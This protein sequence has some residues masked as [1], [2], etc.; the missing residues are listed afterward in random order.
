MGTI[1]FMTSQLPSG[2]DPL[3]LLLEESLPR[4]TATLSPSP[5]VPQAESQDANDTTPERSSLSTADGL[6]R[7]DTLLITPKTTEDAPAS[8]LGQNATSDTDSAVIDITPQSSHLGAQFDEPLPASVSGPATLIPKEKFPALQSSDL[9]FP[10]LRN[11]E[12]L[13]GARSKHVAASEPD[14]GGLEALKERR[15]I[16]FGG[17]TNL[18]HSGPHLEDHAVPTSPSSS[19]ILGDS[20]HVVAEQLLDPSFSLTASSSSRPRTSYGGGSESPISPRSMSNRAR[21]GLDENWRGWVTP[22]A[23]PSIGTTVEGIGRTRSG[24]S[25]S[26]T[27]SANLQGGK[28]S[29]LEDLKKSLTMTPIARKGESAQAAIDRVSTLQRPRRPSQAEIEEQ[30]RQISRTSATFCKDDDLGRPMPSSGENVQPARLSISSLGSS[31]SHGLPRSPPPRANDG[32]TADE[33]PEMPSCM[34]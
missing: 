26:S 19:T 18:S 1:V 33:L 20:D 10:A 28:S 23:T 2:P 12:L 13:L 9:Q 3:E 22:K 34:Y 24:R 14:R 7:R 31:S 29:T 8:Q 27:Q 15:K 6:E 17:I 25:A 30:Q 32:H 11:H 4:R 16:S 21:L 5:S